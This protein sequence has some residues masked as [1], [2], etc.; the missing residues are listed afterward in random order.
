[1]SLLPPRDLK[2]TPLVLRAYVC[3]GCGEQSWPGRDGLSRCQNTDRCGTYA[4]ITVRADEAMQGHLSRM[5]RAWEE[6]RHLRL[7]ALDARAQGGSEGRRRQ[8]SEKA[9]SSMQQ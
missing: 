2:R 3:L 5:H 7:V 1:M 9:S 6:E 4:Q 8:R